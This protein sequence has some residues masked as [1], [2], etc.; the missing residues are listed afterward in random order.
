M[1]RGQSPAIRT[2]NRP[3]RLPGARNR[4]R[5]RCLLTALGR[6][7]RERI[8]LDSQRGLDELPEES[9][10]LFHEDHPSVDLPVPADQLATHQHDEEKRNRQDDQ[11][12]HVLFHG[13]TVTPPTPFHKRA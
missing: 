10:L 7:M 13:E 5:R 12:A 4:R 1:L 11:P 9:G 3:A 6:L 8:L 2:R